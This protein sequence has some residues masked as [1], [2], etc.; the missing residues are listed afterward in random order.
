MEFW[1]SING[2]IPGALIL[3]IGLPLIFLGT[4]RPKEKLKKEEKKQQKD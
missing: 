1:A 4:R 2:Y 3:L